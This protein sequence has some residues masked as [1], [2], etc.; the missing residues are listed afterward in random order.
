MKTTKVLIFGG[1]ST[2]AREVGK[3]LIRE[4]IPVLSY[5]RSSNQ[6]FIQVS[7]YS[8]P[9]REIETGEI[10]IIFFAISSP[11]VCEINPGTSFAVNVIATNDV[12][13]ETLNRGGRVI[14]ISSDVV[15]GNTTKAV[16]ESSPLNPTGKY[17]I[18]KS[19]VEE[20][21]SGNEGFIAIRTSL[22]LSNNN[23][24]VQKFLSGQQTTLLKNLSRN[25]LLTSDLSALIHQVIKMPTAQWPRALNAGGKELIDIA[26]YFTSMAKEMGYNGLQVV[27]WDKIDEVCKPKRIEM[28]SDLAQ[29]I[30]KRPFN[31]IHSFVPTL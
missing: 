19:L 21:W 12:I 31:S 26:D 25:V 2:L 29:S 9:A 5:S 24:I 30:L 1:T 16:S 7:D 18:Q 23:Q 8:V 20:T 28:D 27:D 3:F 4:E 10:V 6:S 14:F 17:G 13:K 22:N 11:R 15:Y